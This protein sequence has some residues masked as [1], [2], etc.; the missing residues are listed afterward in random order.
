[1]SCS[2]RASTW[3][4]ASVG[5]EVCGLFGIGEERD[6]LARAGEDQVLRPGHRLD[7]D[8]D[9]VGHALH[10]Q[11]SL[12]ARHPG[13]GALRDDAAAGGGLDAVR[14]R[15]PFLVQRD[16][17]QQQHHAGAAAAQDVGG[18][19]D[20]VRRGRCG[21]GSTRQRLGD[22]AARRSRTCRTAGS[23]WRSAPARS[24]TPAPRPR[25]RAPTVRT[26]IEVRTQPDTPRAQPSV[27]A[28]SGGSSGR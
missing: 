25:H 3:I 11:A 17:A 4:S 9:D 16:A 10:R 19:L 14:Q 24:S 6:R 28:V 27:S 8:I 23:A 1:M 15:Q 26:S 18:L 5:I 20:L 7:R 2:G 21:V 13:V 22:D 12:A